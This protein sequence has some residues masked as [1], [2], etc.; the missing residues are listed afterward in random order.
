MVACFL[1]GVLFGLALKGYELNE[2][3]EALQI[4]E[5]QVKLLQEQVSVLR[6]TVEAQRKTIELYKSLVEHP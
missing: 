3:L 4:T 2:A 6:D 1:S 5:D